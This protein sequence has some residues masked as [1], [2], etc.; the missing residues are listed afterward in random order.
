VAAP[1]TIGTTTDSL[2]F[3]LIN[4][5]APAVGTSGSKPVTQSMDKG[6]RLD[7]DV[8][9]L[10]PQVGHKVEITGSV[11]EPAPT[12]ASATS[13]NGPMVKVQSIKMLSETCGR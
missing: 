10:N 7:G 13:A 1:S 5:P 11:T 3:V 9:K 8:E 12:N 6:Y 2:H 4:T